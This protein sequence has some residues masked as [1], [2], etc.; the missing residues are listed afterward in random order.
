[1]LG[2]VLSPST[3]RVDRCEKFNAYIQIPTLQEY[4]LIEQAVPYVELF[5]RSNAW[6]REVLKAGD[7]LR[8]ASVEFEIAV[9][10]L[11]RRVEF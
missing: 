8:L 3:E 2:E 5:R 9:D 11:Y 10:A 6:Q 1:M 7:M 4:V